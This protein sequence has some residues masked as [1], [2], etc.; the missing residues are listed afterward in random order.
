MNSVCQT[1]S[2]NT[3]QNA[4]RQVLAPLCG[5]EKWHWK[6]KT[7]IQIHTGISIM[8]KAII[9]IHTWTLIMKKAVIQ[10]HT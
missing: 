3:V 9:Q 10:I 2:F 8:K 7:I 6:K 1:F 5:L 4:W